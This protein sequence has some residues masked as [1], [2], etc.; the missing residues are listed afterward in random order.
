MA[1]ESQTVT[2][3]VETA[4][5]SQV[6]AALAD[7]AE[8]L[9]RL[10][11][12]ARIEHVGSTAV[13]GSVTKGDLDICVLVNG[14]EFGEAVSRLDAHY[15]RNTGSDWSSEFAAFVAPD[16]DP[17]AVGVQLVVAGS[18][19]DVFVRWRELLLADAQLRGEYDRLKLRHEGA[20]MESY[21]AEKSAFIEA[22]LA[23][24]AGG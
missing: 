19:A 9:R 2:F 18:A 12:S 1:E 6:A 24:H 17:A 20:S 15:A 13:P 10:L 23:A 22:A 5:R 7:H 21:R 11:P 16:G 4:W 14:P 8:R 3:A